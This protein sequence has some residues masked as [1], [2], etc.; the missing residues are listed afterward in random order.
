MSG[1]PVYF[2]L[3][4]EVMYCPLAKFFHFIGQLVKA[5]YSS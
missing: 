3:H 2:S 4:V 1:D 5:M